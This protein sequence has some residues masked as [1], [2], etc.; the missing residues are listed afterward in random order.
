MFMSKCKRKNYDRIMLAFIS[1]IGYWQEQGHLIMNIFRN[2]LNII[3]EYPVENFHSLIR[4]YTGQNVPSSD[5]LRRYG[6]FLDY[7]KHNNK[8]IIDLLP[9]HKKYSNTIKQLDQKVQCASTFL[10]N[11]FKEFL[12]NGGVCERKETQK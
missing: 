11:F 2:H 10:L 4:R 12:K 7:E 9:K 6:V 1:D 3:D 5:T 8:F